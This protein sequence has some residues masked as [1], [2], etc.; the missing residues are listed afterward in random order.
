[1]EGGVESTTLQYIIRDFDM[2]KYE[3]RKQLFEAL[4]AEFREK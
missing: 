3:E 4:C 2:E 1:M